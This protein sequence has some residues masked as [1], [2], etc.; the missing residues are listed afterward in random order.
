M[1]ILT[2]GFPGNPRN[3][4]GGKGPAQIHSMGVTIPY[5]IFRESCGDD[6]GSG[7]TV[8]TFHGSGKL[9][10]TRRTAVSTTNTED[11]TIRLFLEFR[12]E[13]RTVRKRS[14]SLGTQHCF[15]GRHVFIEPRLHFFKELFGSGETCIHQ[16]N[17]LL[18]QA[19]QPGSHPKGNQFITGNSGVRFGIKNWPS[20]ASQASPRRPN[21][22]DGCPRGSRT[23]TFV[24]PE[25]ADPTRCL[26]PIQ[27]AKMIAPTINQPQYRSGTKM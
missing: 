24:A 16:V 26:Q 22:P 11:D 19:V 17:R 8:L 5:D 12:P 3:R 15:D 20:C 7:H 6:G 27:D 25:P 2:Q 1:N 10:E 21:I 9:G 14:A 13:I 18:F 4:I 23:V